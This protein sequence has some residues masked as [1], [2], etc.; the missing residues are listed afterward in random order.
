MAI[1]IDRALPSNFPTKPTT[2]APSLLTYPRDLNAPGRNFCTQIDFKP[3]NYEQALQSV[4]SPSAS[5]GLVL[6]IPKKI[7]EQQTVIWKQESLLSL[8]ASIGAQA[9]SSQLPKIGNIAGAIAGIGNAAAGIGLGLTVNPFLWML[10]QSPDFKEH[11]FSWTL[12]ANNPQES[13]DIATIIN[14][15]K[16]HMSPAFFGLKAFYVYPSIAHIKFFPNDVFTFKL[17][18]CAILAVNVDYS[19]AGMPSFFKNGAPTIVNITVLLK[20]IGLWTKEDF[21]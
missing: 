11:T 10:F 18:P 21:Q 19:G 20:E 14:A 3:Y 5:S 12:A 15:F 7:N 17:K 8:G 9:I 2:V 6:P 1:N 16:Y 13:N 4:A